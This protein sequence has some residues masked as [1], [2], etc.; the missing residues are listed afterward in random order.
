M[1]RLQASKTFVCMY[2]ILHFCANPQKFQ[3]L[4]PAKNSH[5]KVHHLGTL[6]K[7]ADRKKCQEKPLHSGDQLPEVRGGGGEKNKERW[8]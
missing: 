3:T 2:K 7:K 1:R 6:Y 8:I 5:L 4:V